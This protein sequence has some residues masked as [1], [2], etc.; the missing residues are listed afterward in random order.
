[1]RILYIGN[2]RSSQAF[3]IHLLSLGANIVGLVTRSQ[4]SNSDHADLYSIAS[5]RSVPTF[6]Y[7]H[8]TKHLLANFIFSCQPDYIFCF[9]WSTLLS[10]EVLEIP[11]Y[12]SIGFHPAAL[13]SNKGRHPIIWTLALGLASTAS[14]FFYL[15]TRADDGPIVSQVTLPVHQD[16]TASSLYDRIIAVACNQLTTL[17]SK[18]CVGPL[19]GRPQSGVTNHWRKRSFKDGLIDWRMSGTAIYNLVRAL[20]HPYPCAHLLYN[21]NVYRILSVQ[22]LPQSSPNIEP[23]KVVSVNP[24]ITVQ[25]FDSLVSLT[26]LDNIPD[27]SVNDYL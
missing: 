15:T 27:I 9:G 23:G 8:E 2:V 5:S 7:S 20:S 19:T 25:C 14:T 26:M 4:S 6:T 22:I 16:D 3:L 11:K 17:H 12:G 24:S 13:P 10:S 21:N 1:M 18:I